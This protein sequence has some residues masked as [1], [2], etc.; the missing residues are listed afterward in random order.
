[1]SDDRTSSFPNFLLQQFENS[2]LPQMVVSVKHNRIIRANNSAYSQLGVNAENIKNQPFTALYSDSFGE[3]YNFSEE[4]LSYG[5]AYTRKLSLPLGG[6]EMLPVEHFGVKCSVNDEDCIHITTFNLDHFHKRKIDEEADIYQRKGYEEWRRAERFFREIELQNQMILKAA[7]EGIYGVNAHGVTIFVNKAAESILGWNEED[8]VGRDMHSIVHYA[9]PDGSTYHSEDCPI[10]GAFRLGKVAHVDNEVFWNKNGK[11]IQVE[12]TSTPIIDD[13]ENLGAVIVFRDVSQRRQREEQLRQ[14]L[15]DNARLRERLEQEN[16]YLQEE[17]RFKTNQSDIIGVSSEVR[18]IHS[19]IELAAP[20]DAS[21]LITGESGTG[22]ELVANALHQ[23][24]LRKDHPLI[25]VNCAAIP[26]ELFE[27]EFFGHSKGA[28]T[29]AMRDRVGRFELANGGTLFLDEIGE[30][31]LDLQSKLLRVLQDQKFERVGEEKTRSSDVRLIA[32]TNRDLKKEVEAGRF[33][34][35]LYFRLNVFPIECAPLRQRKEDVP[36]LAEAFLTQAAK[37]MKLDK[38][39]LTVGNMNML[40]AYDW[41]GN[42]RELQN[43]IERAVILAQNGRVILSLPTTNDFAPYSKAQP[44][45]SDEMGA[46]FREVYTIQ[47]F[48]ELEKQNII[49]AL[50]KCHGKVSGKFGAAKLLN[51]KPTT[52]YS[53]IRKFEIKSSSP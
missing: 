18:S 51:I 37:R 27:S 44:E 29:G 40:K 48:N 12:Y 7:G 10:Y 13:G 17:I 31:P 22:K 38:P 41:P 9:H 23:A 52:L 20:T 50:D 42:V 14:A 11:P 5:F 39:T 28:F 6:E 24:S 32:A 47:E 4:I 15:E 19:Q 49:L 46:D 26:H 3:L 35:D 45:S 16:A 2:D 34:E 1:M 8:L 21:I 30:I 53:K 33:R 43:V 36:L 25:R